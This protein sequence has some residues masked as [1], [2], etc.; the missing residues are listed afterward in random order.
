VDFSIN[1]DLQLARE[2]AH[3]L[4]PAAYLPLLDAP[5]IVAAGGDESSEFHRQARLLHESWGSVCHGHKAGL[6]Y[7]TGLNHFTVMDKFCDP[8]HTLYK[9]FVDLL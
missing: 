2:E 3:R 9:Q 8:A 6:H 7:P 5:L 1:A 4:S